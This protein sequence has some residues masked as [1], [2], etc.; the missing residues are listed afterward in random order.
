[1]GLSETWIRLNFMFWR[2]HLWAE[3]CTFN[4]EYH[5]VPFAK[6]RGKE[7]GKE[8]GQVF[9]DW[10]QNA[11]IQIQTHNKNTRGQMRLFVP[12]CVV[13]KKCLFRY[14]ATA[15]TINIHMTRNTHF[16]LCVCIRIIYVY[17]WRDIRKF[18][19]CTP[20]QGLCGQWIWRRVHDPQRRF[21]P[22]IQSA[23]FGK[24]DECS[25]DAV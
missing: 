21:T 11:C 8:N 22:M 19:K 3:P 24:S 12:L 9:E 16:F 7:K 1:M 5:F 13:K 6:E 4:L 17:I 2:N 25:V 20:Q 18:D 14:A 15:H 23:E 10:L